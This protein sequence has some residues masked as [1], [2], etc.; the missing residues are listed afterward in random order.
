MKTTQFLKFLLEDMSISDAKKLFGLSGN[1]DAGDI[2]KIYRKLSMKYHPDRRGGSNDMMSKVN[3]AREILQKQYGKAKN[4]KS[5]EDAVKDSQ[6]FREREKKYEAELEAI[7]KYVQ[8]FLKRFEPDVYRKYIEETFKKQIFITQNKPY[9]R[10]GMRLEL[11]DA[12]RDIVFTLDFFPKDSEWTLHD[13]IFG[14]DSPIL[15]LNGQIIEFAFHS[16]VLIN[17]K[18]QVLQKDYTVMSNNPKIFTDPTIL[19]PAMRMKK[20]ASGLVRK[21]KVAIR[22]FN[23]M[24]VRQFGAKMKKEGSFYQWAIAFPD[25]GFWVKVFRYHYRMGLGT[26]YEVVNICKYDADDKWHPYS[27]DSLDPKYYTEFRKIFGST[28]K[29]NLE[30]NEETLKLFQ[31]SLKQLKRDGN[32]KKFVDTF[33]NAMN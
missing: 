33:R 5:Y 12:E 28:R 13:Q 30:E 17:G 7:R 16:F 15:S 8:T 20:L 2:A 4:G 18:K 6:N 11:A 19:L 32:L 10:M 24:F 23:A 1:E 31:D 29:K 26:Y 25:K 3:Q 22:D 14:S 21:G 9:G 27:N